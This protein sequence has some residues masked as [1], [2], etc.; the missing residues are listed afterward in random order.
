M[1][2]EKPR[3]SDAQ[4]ELARR[5]DEVIRAMIATPPRKHKDEP[6]KRARPKPDVKKS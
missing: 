2:K 5:R 3:N 6:K 1:K 4:D